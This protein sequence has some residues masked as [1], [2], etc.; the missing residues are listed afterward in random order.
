[1]RR[2]PPR[3]TRTD[4]LFPYTTLF[5]STAVGHVN[6]P[7]SGINAIGRQR[8]SA[9]NGL[10]FRN[11]FSLIFRPA[12]ADGKGIRNG[13][14]ISHLWRRRFAPNWRSL[15]AG[16]AIITIKRCS[17]ATGIISMRSEE[18]TAELQSQMRITY[19]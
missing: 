2:R 18:H 19:A 15:P 9:A 14:E 17:V 5:R 4:T 8:T 10:F 11:R 7:F 13:A 6:Q 16:P 3:S 12:E 1:M